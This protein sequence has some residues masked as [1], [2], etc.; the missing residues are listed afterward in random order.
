MDADS[1][2]PVAVVVAS[3][4]ENEKKHTE[5]LLDKASLVVDGF[6]VVVADSQRA[7]ELVIKLRFLD[8]SL[9]LFLIVTS[10]T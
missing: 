10:V 7:R 2:M 5:E 9:Y 1:D 8:S 4:N 3:A 6:E